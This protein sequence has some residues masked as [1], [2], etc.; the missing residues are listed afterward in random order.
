MLY[1]A[2]LLSR[3]EMVMKVQKRLLVLILAILT[4]IGRQVTVSAS[5][6][7]TAVS[8][9]NNTE[10]N[11]TSQ[12][13][14][15][16]G[17]VKDK[18]GIIQTEKFDIK[19]DWGIE[20]NCRQGAPLPITVTIE[21][22]QEDFQGRIR[23]ITSKVEGYSMS[24]AYEQEVLLTKNTPKTIQ[25]A[26]EHYIDGAKIKFELEDESGKNILSKEILA[27]AKV[28]SSAL[29][30]ILSDDYSALGY[31][32]KR[33]CE[34]RDYFDQ[35]SIVEL[36]EKNMPNKY[37]AI[38]ALSYLVIDNYD[39]SKLSKDQFETIKKWVE[40]GGY[41]IIG[42]GSNY[43]Q[44]LSAFVEDSE[45]LEGTVKGMKEGKLFC[46]KSHN[47]ALSFGKKDG[48]ADITIKDGEN[49]LA[50]TS[51]ENML[52]EKKFH[53]GKIVVASF[54]WGMDPFRN[55]SFKEIFVE[56]LLSEVAK[57]SSRL[58]DIN[59]HE[60]QYNINC[61]NLENCVG[62]SVYPNW[63]IL[64]FLI[65]AF[66]ISALTIYFILKKLDK[67]GWIWIV[68][69]TLAIVFTFLNLAAT[70]NI[71]IKSPQV[72]SL[73]V[74]YSDE[75]GNKSKNIDMSIMVPSTNEETVS[76]S[77]DLV[78]GRMKYSY[79]G[80]DN[81]WN[82]IITEEEDKYNYN[83]AMRDTS[84]GYVYRIKN[85]STFTYNYYSFSSRKS[86]FDEILETKFNRTLDGLSGS[87]KNISDKD[88]KYATV[89]TYGKIFLIGDIKAGE[90]KEFKKE[91]GIKCYEL[92]WDELTMPG[93]DKYSDEYS[94]LCNLY[95]YL[96]PTYFEDMFINQKDLGTAFT[97]GYME[98]YES[99]YVKDEDIEETND[100][101][102]VK[103]DRLEI[104]EYSG[105]KVLKLNTYA[106]GNDKWDRSDGLLYE[107]V[108]EEEF[109]LDEEIS[110]IYVIER[111]AES[112]YEYGNVQNTVVSFWNYE[113]GR[114]EEVFTKDLR[115]VFNGKCPYINENNVIK[116][117]FTC[118]K[119]NEDMVPFITIIGGEK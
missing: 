6:E 58:A 37:D 44:T 5:T 80:R 119:P 25:M 75:N 90:T 65:V 3:K 110:S 62:K 85:N 102:I 92:Y 45:M 61:F 59:F 64:A 12:S 70:S 14:E 112:Q 104:E 98:D 106:M 52:V 71:R 89:I 72:A 107:K 1:F 49:M 74:L 7:S 39:T 18:M 111:A 50:L 46:G 33:N 77:E 63:G 88:I 38:V 103:K 21:S 83:S 82:R 60:E 55:W 99:D 51:S 86:E 20:R 57:D 17:S 16:S 108:V 42:T 30:G 22:I 35:T 28:D 53:K 76:M 116:A 8:E 66:I 93:V 78:N 73:S 34:G 4:L 96:T 87:V 19:I 97:V 40:A 26:I 95:N 94:K 23:F 41:L 100:S 24:Y 68:F 32:D 109:A 56:S 91:D 2:G 27:S 15:E 114:Y 118:K 10:S 47:K 115:L 84:D 48:L 36:N 117:K 69:P 81:F 11:T 31:W 9:E 29:V 43:Q 113:R 79:D 13:N 105:A 101:L 67:R 54:N